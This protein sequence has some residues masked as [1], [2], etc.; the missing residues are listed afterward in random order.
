MR[1]RLTVW[2]GDPATH[3]A[4]WIDAAVAEAPNYTLEARLLPEVQLNDD[5]QRRMDACIAAHIVL[6][7]EPIRRAAPHLTVARSRELASTMINVA[8][9]PAVTRIEPEPE[10]LRWQFR[11][12]LR[13]P[14]AGPH[15]ELFGELFVPR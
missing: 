10:A 14:A 12:L 5:E 4:D 15:S 11:A 7:A 2:V 13:Q 9:A 8:L 3:I 6:V 1:P